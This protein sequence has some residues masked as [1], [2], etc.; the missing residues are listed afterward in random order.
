MFLV[1]RYGGQESVI[2]IKNPSI[3]AITFQS[4][5]TA[6]VEPDFLD[7]PLGICCVLRRGHVMLDVI[8]TFLWH[9]LKILDVV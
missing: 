7:R 1:V 9:H 6:E 2:N 3:F 8:Y 4:T 5:A